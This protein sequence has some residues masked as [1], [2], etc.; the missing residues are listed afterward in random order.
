MDCLRAV[1]SDVITE[2]RR[3]CFAVFEHQ[4]LHMSRQISKPKPSQY[5]M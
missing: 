5:S 2:V 3:Q 1:R 4:G